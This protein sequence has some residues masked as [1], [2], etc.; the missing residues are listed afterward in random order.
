MAIFSVGITLMALLGDCAVYNNY[1]FH[2]NGFVWNLITAPG[3]IESMGCSS[4][5]HLSAHYCHY[6]RNIFRSGRFIMD[7]RHP[8]PPAAFEA[9]S[10]I[11]Q[12]VFLPAYTIHHPWSR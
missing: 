11:T 3:G 12:T 10:Q 5:T 2:L 1:N 9:A 8:V 4:S 7:Y 6:F